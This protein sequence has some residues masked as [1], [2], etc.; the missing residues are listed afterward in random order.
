[1]V[2]LSINLIGPLEAAAVLF[3]VGCALLVAEVFFPSG[4]VLGLCS[5]TAFIAAVWFAFDGGGVTYG[6]SFA[7]AEVVGAPVLLYFAFKY[8]PYTPLGRT[9]VGEAPTEAEVLPDEDRHELVGRVGVARSKMLPSGAVEIE[10]QVLDAVSQGRPIDPGQY[11]KVVEVRGNRVVVRPASTGERPRQESAD[12]SD[13]LTRP[14]E[15]L[16]MDDNPLA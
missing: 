4:G 6:L 13:L 15:D 16:G 11:V 8:L 14:L 10:G 7:L 9:L 3:V 12:P 1:M 2:L 5:A